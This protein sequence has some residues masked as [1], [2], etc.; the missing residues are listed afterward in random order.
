MRCGIKKNIAGAVGF[1][2]TVCWILPGIRADSGDYSEFEYQE[3]S[4]GGG[5]EI[6]GYNGTGGDVEI[7]EEIDEKK[8]IGIRLSGENCASIKSITIPDSVRYSPH[9]ED[10]VSL[11]EINVNE[12]N[13][14]FSSIDGV[15]YN[16]TKT[17]LII[18][19]GG[20]SGSFTIPEGVTS[21]D[22]CAFKNCIHLTDVSIPASMTGKL[23]NYRDIYTQRDPK[24]LFDNCTS[25]TEINID[26]NNKN[27]SSVDGVVYNKSVTNMLVCPRGRDSITIPDSVILIGEHPRSVDD[28]SIITNCSYIDV[29]PENGKYHTEDEILYG[30]SCDGTKT[31]IFC[32]RGKKGS[33]TISNGTDS[34]C[35]NAFAHCELITSVNIPDSL[36]EVI[37]TSEYDEAAALGGPEGFKNCSSLFEINVDANNPKYLS[38]DGV[39]FDK[40]M[41]KLILYPAGKTD[42][43][44][45][46]PEGVEEIPR[47]TFFYNKD[48][49]SVTV[50]S[51]VNNLGEFLGE[52]N[53]YFGRMDFSP[54]AYCDSLT[55]IKVNSKNE[56]YK[57][58]N[59]ALYSKDGKRLI[60]CPAGTA[61]I[62]SVA[63]GTD[64]IERT[65][66]VDCSN[67]K[68][69]YIPN[70]VK[71]IKINDTEIDW[72]FAQRLSSG[73]VIYGVKGSEA[74]KFAYKYELEFMSV[75]TENY[76]D[77]N[78]GV[79][80]EGCFPPETAVYVEGS[81]KF[82]DEGQRSFDI[83]FT[84]SDKKERQPFEAVTVRIPLPEG[85]DPET[86]RVYRAE[87]YGVY[88][89]M[90]AVYFDGSMCFKTDHFST[91]IISDQPMINDGK[92]IGGEG[93][94]SDGKNVSDADSGNPSDKNNGKKD[95]NKSTGL[96]IAAIP[97]VMAALIGAFAAAG[98]GK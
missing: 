37:I 22:A 2:L 63:D 96:I 65:A 47:G 15:L 11:T 50:S 10:C 40:D 16:K 76:E 84:D 60:V 70:S 35:E 93:T 36:Q 64:I 13:E 97:P 74:E 55:E 58:I 17:Q 86:C 98:K 3:I 57:S 51:S 71:E 73:P 38:V 95:P 79:R 8:V 90:K 27:Y 44:Y 80:I 9:L 68:Y 20:K 66:F 31:L 26:E 14:F 62:F 56:A 82:I 1:V 48:L 6:T 23:Y 32:P 21:I 49:I 54:F 34:V 72:W 4:W 94:A 61:D 91:Y 28:L 33:V 87:E 5:L 52:V 83:S 53:D 29:D 81:D 42:K 7:P 85:W 18:C 69:L 78:S 59:G 67:L 77:E 41:K 89:D 75:Y 24:Q 12:Y 45:M 88:T 43:T 39:L 92:E 46:I 19:P 30:T 25:L